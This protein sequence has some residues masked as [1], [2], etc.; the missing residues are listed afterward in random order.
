MASNVSAEKLGILDCKGGTLFTAYAE[1]SVKSG[2]TGLPLAS[3][4]G[5]PKVGYSGELL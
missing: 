5:E 3:T 1:G 2:I 4:K